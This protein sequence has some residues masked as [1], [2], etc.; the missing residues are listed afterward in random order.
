VNAESHDVGATLGLATRLPHDVREA[1]GALSRVARALVGPGTFEELAGRALDEMHRGLGLEVAA[2]YLPDRRE[3]PVLRRFVYSASPEST[4][5]V[6][7]ELTLEPEAWRLAVQSPAPLVFFA[8]GSALV[9]SPFEP[10]PESWLAL[11]LASG[12]RMLGVVIA[13]GP[14]PPRLDPL[15]ATVLTLLGDLLGAGIATARLRQRLQIAALERERLELATEVHDE[16]AQDLALAARELRLLD[17]D[18][19]PREAAASRARL[20]EAVQ[21]AHGTARARLMGLMAPVPLGGLR[22][23]V[24]EICRRFAARRVPV[25]LEPGEEPPEVG[26]EARA[27]VARIL[28]E[29][30]ANVEKHAAA[31]EVSV[32]LSGA[33]ERLTLVVRDDGNGIAPGTAPQTGEGHFGLQLMHQRALAAG[34]SVTVEPATPHGTR[35]VLVLPIPEEV[36]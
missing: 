12:D 7:H 18:P 32:E 14:G 15:G 25:R 35:V 10:V 1:L 17:E 6:Q 29:A 22:R 21:S 16:L 24:E 28:A 34:G 4:R 9:A 13:A 27:V 8:E 33:D 3:G 30:L 11:P 2:L 19:A 20:R 5:G 31:S 26:A 23:S 36:V